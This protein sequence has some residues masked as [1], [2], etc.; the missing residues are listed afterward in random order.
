[1]K[2][3]AFIFPPYF[4]HQP[5]YSM[6]V[7]DRQS[8]DAGEQLEG[9]S[10][11]DGDDVN[12]DVTPT[13]RAKSARAGLNKLVIEVSTETW[14]HQARFAARAVTSVDVC[15]VAMHIA[16]RPFTFTCAGT[17]RASIVRQASNRCHAAEICLHAVA[18][19]PVKL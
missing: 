13:Q 8:R 15:C 3:R 19:G 11:S 5:L 9:D 10:D 6:P 2:G 16:R 7:L 1:M 4:S 18:I 14:A 17:L 12:D